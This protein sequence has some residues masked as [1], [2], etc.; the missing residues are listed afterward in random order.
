MH[1]RIGD[2]AL[3][4]DCHSAALVGRDGSVDWACFPR[5]D[6][7]SVFARILDVNR[8]GSM[9]VRPARIRSIERAYLNDTNVLVT[10]FTCDTGVLEVTDCMPIGRL[11]P[12]DLTR[13]A[14]REAILRRVRCTEGAVDVTLVVAPRFE[15]GDLVPL[16]SLTSDR[17][18]RIVGGAHALWVTAS[19]RLDWQA[20]ALS[21]SW[22]LET[23]Q[24]EWL[25]VD[26]TP[27]NVQRGRTIPTRDAYERRLEDTIAYWR[28]W[29]DR[30]W[31]E[32]EHQE[33]VRRSALV[34]KALTYAPTGAVVAAPTT[35]LPEEI[36]GERNWDYRYTWIR[37]AT[38][39]LTS[40]FVLGFAE[41][42]DAFKTWLALASAGRAG[43]LQIMYGIRG[44]RLLPEFTLDHLDGHRESRP[45]RVGNAAARQ[46]QLDM[47]GQI[48]QSAYLYARAG[49]RV[50]PA[51]WLFLSELAQ[52]VV[53]RW[54]QP[55][56]GIWEVRGRS[57]HFTHS[58]LN[59]WMALDRAV[60]LAALV[61]LPAPVPRWQT[62]RD[63]IRAW[64]LHEA[65]PDG[66]F[67]QAAE[68]DAPDAATLLIPAF[69]FLPVAD[70]LVQRTIEVVCEQLS[71]DGLVD[72]YRVEDGLAGGEGA[73]LLCSFWL[74]D[75]LTHAGRLDEA[76][77]LLERLL[78]LANDVGLYAEEVDPAT[79]ELLGNFPQAFTHMALV[80]S[81]AHLSAAKRGEVP[82]EGAHDYSELALDRL[83]R[84][85]GRTPQAGLQ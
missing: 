39:T 58:K 1:N 73:F 20:E 60:R 65:A 59:C 16:F 42:A 40:L 84:A 30:C 50:R 22:H 10:T 78:G 62:V 61:D 32:G 54:D 38:L 46:T 48:L 45:V 14:A 5:F 7:P 8:G 72:R 21:G 12:D 29:I 76:D 19:A 41:E 81:C 75:C 82:F 13:V 56:R 77:R 64:L 74:L 80:T 44:R 49:G 70:P 83:L 36:R 26:W 43:D 85:Q 31:Y 68:V 57:R 37:D 2:Y 11:D 28:A 3:I 53:Q 69:G 24:A 27:S 34:L 25:E 52:Q 9:Q 15:Y 33:A 66:W 63:R 71:Y 18:G 51:E 55:D 4:G 23:G 6:S 67:R 35:S 17:T 47:Y 79:G